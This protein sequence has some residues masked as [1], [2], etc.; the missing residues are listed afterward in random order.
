LTKSRTSRATLA[1]VRGGRFS[2]DPVLLLFPPTAAD[3]AAAEVVRVEES[4]RVEDERRDGLEREERDPPRMELLLLLLLTAEW[5]RWDRYEV[6]AAAAE[7]DDDAVVPPLALDWFMAEGG[8]GLGAGEVMLESSTG[9]GGLRQMKEW[10]IDGDVSYDCGEAQICC[11]S[12]CRRQFRF[13][14][15]SYVRQPVNSCL[16]GW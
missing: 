16:S 7:V 14:E 4:E 1:N 2:L 13:L 6:E 5:V 11:W 12:S 3:D 15:A 8:R 9:E 10:C